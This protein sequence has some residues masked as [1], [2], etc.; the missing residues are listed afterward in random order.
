M[1]RGH[2]ENVTSFARAQNVTTKLKVMLEHAYVRNTK[3]QM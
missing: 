3:T 1:I 2:A